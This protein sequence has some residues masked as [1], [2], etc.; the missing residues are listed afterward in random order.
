MS[1]ISNDNSDSDNEWFKNDEKF[2]WNKCPSNKKE[3]YLY[4]FKIKNFLYEK[5]MAL[6]KYRFHILN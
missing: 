4:D 2:S 6:L 1:C 5:M 3:I